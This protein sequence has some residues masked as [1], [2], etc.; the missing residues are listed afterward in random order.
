MFL[1]S[2]FISSSKRSQET[3]SED[4]VSVFA[5]YNSGA[6]E[7][8]FGGSISYFCVSRRL[9]SN[10]KLFIGGLS[11]ETNKDS[12]KDYFE[13]Y[14]EIVDVVVMRDPATKRSRGF[15]FVTYA[16]PKSVE[17]CL[18]AGKHHSLGELVCDTFYCS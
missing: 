13:K 6:D 15:G 14:G 3:M 5:S 10:A 16:D 18:A 4:T 2:D 7:G 17:D 8:R 12:L 9:Q 1:T 11:L